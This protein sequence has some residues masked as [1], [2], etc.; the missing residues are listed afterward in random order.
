MTLVCDAAELE[1]HLPVPPSVTVPLSGTVTLGSRSPPTRSHE[2]E[3]ECH[4]Q[5]AHESESEHAR[6]ASVR[7]S[8]PRTGTGRPVPGALS[9][10]FECG[11]SEGGVDQ[12]ELQ[13][14]HWPAGRALAVYFKLKTPSPGRSARGLGVT[15]SESVPATRR[16]FCQA[17]LFEA[18][19]HGPCPRAGDS[20]GRQEL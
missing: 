20:D 6:P 7:A 11:D 2:S 1:P 4:C 19:G 9:C 8:E 14:C 12:L 10:K 13:S 3:P 16:G 15:E 17:E 18:H 5:C